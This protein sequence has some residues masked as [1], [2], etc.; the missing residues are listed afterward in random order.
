MNDEYF[1]SVTHRF[2]LGVA[3]FIGSDK[4]ILQ[5]N[6]IGYEYDELTRLHLI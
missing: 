4:Q 6:G 1:V 2:Q 5:I 3:K